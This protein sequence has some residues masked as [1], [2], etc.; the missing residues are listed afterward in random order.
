MT[1]APGQTDITTL[2]IVGTVCAFVALALWASRAIETHMIET[3]A[4]NR[5]AEIRRRAD[6]I[7]RTE[8]LRNLRGDIEIA[9]TANQHQRK[10]GSH[11]ECQTC[12]AV[13]PQGTNEEKDA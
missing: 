6:H 3:H 2:L 9:A 1:T 5:V 10:K 8:E 11:E 12:G 13:H 7:R 4:R